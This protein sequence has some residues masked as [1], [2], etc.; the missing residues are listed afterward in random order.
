MKKIIN[1]VLMLAIAALLLSSCGGKDSI[2]PDPNPNNGNHEVLWSYDIGFGSM[3]DVLPAVD[4]NDNI[5]FSMVKEDGTTV[6]TVALDKNGTKIWGNEVAGE[7]TDKV[8]YYDG[9]VFIVTDVPSAIYCLDASNGNAL[10][11]K[12][13]TLDYDFA[14]IPRL[15]LNNNKLY[16]SSGQF[17]Y[18][19]LLAYDMD[20]NE[21]WVKKGP[22]MG[23]SFNLSVID[24]QLYFMDD[25]YLFRYDDNGTSCD[26]IWAFE[27][28]NLKKGNRDRSLITLFDLPIGADGNIYFREESITIVSPNGELVNSINLD[29]SYNEG[30]ASN[31]LLTP[32]NDIIIGKGNLVKMNNNG[33]VIW[34]SDI[35]DGLI[36]NPAFT[37]APVISSNENFYDAQLFGL[38]CVKSSGE[39]DWKVNSENGGGTEYGN[40]HPLVLTHEG[41]II[42]VSSEQKMVRCFKGDGNG[43][44]NSGWP[45]PYGDYGNTSSK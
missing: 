34:E 27:M 38:Y 30:Y 9:K 12:D 10:W 40:L 20:G 2:I 41:N 37:T 42:S 14:W 31:I 43:L 16:V 18:G 24:N 23:A 3:A 17:F 39:L 5:Y 36:I 28:P 8:T 6:S 19:Y 29:A 15:A 22:T 7:G 4:E 13:L 45:K 11:S 33:D 35:N 32:N 44:A 25:V 21:L 1:S 26:S